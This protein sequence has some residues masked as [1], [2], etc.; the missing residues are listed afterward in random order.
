MLAKRLSVILAIL[1]L[2]PTLAVGWIAYSSWIEGIRTE[3]IKIVGRVADA[4]HTELVTVL[5]KVNS[6]AKALLSDTA[7]QCGHAAKLD[8]RCAKKEIS[9]FLKIEGARG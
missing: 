8:L 7:S 5:A 6:R 1:I 4:K 3:Q 2:L 9:E